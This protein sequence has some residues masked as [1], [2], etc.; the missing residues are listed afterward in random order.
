MVRALGR[1][2]H[3]RH[4][5]RAAGARRGRRADGQPR[6][7]A[8]PCAGWTSARTATAGSAR[9]AS[10]TS[11][12]RR[13]AAG[14]ARHRRPRGR[15]SRWSL[16][17]VRTRPAARARPRYLL[18]TQRA[19]GGWDEDAFTGCGFPGYAV[20]EQRGARIRQGASCPQGSCFAT[21]STAT[22]FRCSRSGDIA[23][24]SA[25]NGVWHEDRGRSTSTGSTR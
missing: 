1:E 10:R 8:A 25:D 16:P 11:S 24:A 9:A 15:C 23:G 3:L 18:D 12:A 2:P 20:G 13:A 22:A 14:R 21:T 19:D 6:P 4:R 5:R 7:C 17:A